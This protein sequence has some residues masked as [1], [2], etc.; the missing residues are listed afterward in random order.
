MAGYRLTVRHGP[1][2]DRERFENLDEAISELR[3]RAEEI[4]GD[5]PL[6]PISAFRD[7]EPG[8]RVAA[9]LELSAGGWLRGREAGVDVMGDGSVVPYGG[10]IRKRPLG[11]GSGTPF[12]AVREELE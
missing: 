1:R 10:G 9:R 5:G 8:Q 4:R 6:A 7:Y 3:S 12:D 2:V 11:T